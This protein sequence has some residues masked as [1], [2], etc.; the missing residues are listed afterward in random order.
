MAR[1]KIQES[2]KKARRSINGMFFHSSRKVRIH[3]IESFQDW[4]SG[5]SG[6]V[7]SQL[8]VNRTVN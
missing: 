4:A 8:I 7:N 3:K 6:D 5:V 2:S 1:C